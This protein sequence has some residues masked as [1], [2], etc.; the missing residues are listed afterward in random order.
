MP[1][2]IEVVLVLPHTHLRFYFFD[3]V[4]DDGNNDKQGGAA[5]GE[6]CHSGNG[7]H[8]YRQNGNDAQK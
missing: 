2:K 7:L 5:D 4:Y 6:R 8:T 1:E 3:E